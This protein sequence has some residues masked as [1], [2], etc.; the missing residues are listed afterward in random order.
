MREASGRWRGAVGP[1]QPKV[2][3][4]QAFRPL[5]RTSVCEPKASGDA[6]LGIHRQRLCDRVWTPFSGDTLRCVCTACP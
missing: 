5:V 3:A 2:T 4:L 1:A 6:A